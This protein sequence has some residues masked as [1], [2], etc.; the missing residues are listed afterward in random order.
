MRQTGTLVGFVL[1]ALVL[2]WGIAR[3]DASPGWDDTGISAA[4]LFATCF[5]LGAISPRYPWL[6]T[7]AVGLWIPMFMIALHHESPNYGSLLAL[8]FAGA[9]AYVGAIGRKMLAGTGISS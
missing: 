2:G 3:I 8:V 4:A 7:A 5:L 1:I 9:G 6:W